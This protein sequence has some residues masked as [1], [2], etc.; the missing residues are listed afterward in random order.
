MKFTSVLLLLSAIAFL[1][2]PSARAEPPNEI[3]GTPVV[4]DQGFLMLQGRQIALWGIDTLAEDQQCW[5]E[6]RAWRCGEQAASTLKHYAEGQ[7]VTCEVKSDLG[8]GR[9]SAQCFRDKS[10]KAHDIARYLVRQGWA[11]DQTETSGGFYKQEQEEARLRRRGIWTSRFQTAA[12]WRDGVQRYVEYE[13]APE[14]EVT[15]K[16]VNQTVIN[17]TIIQAPEPKPEAAQTANNY[18]QTRLQQ[19]NA[20]KET[21][22][23]INIYDQLQD[24]LRKQREEQSEQMLEGK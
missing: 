4:Q 2:I 20:S 6:E 1:A 13:E 10:G 11:M 17:A 3:F 16:T 7:L 12:D 8:G 18:L 5:K 14:P 15:I 19:Q 24:K 22:G 21:V 9:I 23:T